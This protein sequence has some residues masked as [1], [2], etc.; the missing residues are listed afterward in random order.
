MKWRHSPTVS[1]I[2]ISGPNIFSQAISNKCSATIGFYD[3]ATRHWNNQTH[4]Q[5]LDR[6][7]SF[8]KTLRSQ[9]TK[10]RSTVIASASPETLS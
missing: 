8:A 6:A 5:F 1:L 3:R 2:D 9:Q 7:G 10:A 4:E